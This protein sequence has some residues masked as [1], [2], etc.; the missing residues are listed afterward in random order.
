MAKDKKESQ[1]AKPTP[2]PRPAKLPTL[3]EGVVWDTTEIQGFE[4]AVA[5]PETVQGMVAMC[6]GSE[7]IACRKFSRALRIDV[8]SATEGRD[9]LKAGKTPEAKLQ[10]AKELQ[11]AILAY[12]PTARKERAPR[13]PADLTGLDVDPEVLKRLKEAGVKFTI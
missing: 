6:G 5:V 2:A 8:A 11:L 13:K 12:D 7:E 10:I 4:F 9:K 3:P 1:K